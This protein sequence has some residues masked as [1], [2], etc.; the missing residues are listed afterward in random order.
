MAQL[1][2]TNGDAAA[3]PLRASGV[4]GT[5]MAWQDVLHEGPVP[6]GLSLEELASVRARFLAGCPGGL[7]YERVL[8]DLRKRDAQLRQFKRFEEVILWFEADLYDQLQLLQLLGWFGQRELGGTRL[9][10]ICIGSFPGVVP[11][12][13]LGQLSPQQLGSLFETRHPVS[14][15]ELELGRQGWDAFCSDQPRSLQSLLK[16]DLSALPYLRGALM[17][18]LEQYPATDDGLSRSERQI[19]ESMLKGIRRLG[20]L[21]RSSQIE[22]EQHPFAGDA[23]FAIYLAALCVGSEPL[24]QLADGGPLRPEELQGESREAWEQDVEL[25]DAGHAVI[26]GE[27]D[28]VSLLGID[29][30]LGG[31]HLHGRSVPWRWSRSTR[32]IVAR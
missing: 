9:S 8:A 20:P 29:R 5:V 25:T 11:F 10:L 21:F 23:V 6:A 7:R 13:G 2:I 3:V 32:S 14:R 26:A 30:W 15:A 24:L 16:E 12:H 4:Q 19:L 1:H 31:V 18:H 28:R 22:A 27:A 17:R